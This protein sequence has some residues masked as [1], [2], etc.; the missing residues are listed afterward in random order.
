MYY[1]TVLNK[2]IK[3]LKPFFIYHRF[4][5]NWTYFVGKIYRN[6]PIEW[7]YFWNYISLNSRFAQHNVPIL[8]WN[9]KIHWNSIIF[10]GIVNVNPSDIPFIDWYAKGGGLQIFKPSKDKNVI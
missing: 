1:C 6:E 9:C 10:K 3:L 8:F 5:P 2:C 4:L 7:D